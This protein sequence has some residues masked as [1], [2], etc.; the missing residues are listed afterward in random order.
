MY[1]SC[2]RTDLSGDDTGERARPMRVA[3]ATRRRNV[4]VGAAAAVTWRLK[5]AW[6]SEPPRRQSTSVG[7]RHPCVAYRA[8]PAPESRSN[9]STNPSHKS[10]PCCEIPAFVFRETFE[11]KTFPRAIVA[12]NEKKKKDRSTVQFVS[13]GSR[14][15]A[16]NWAHRQNFTRATRRVIDCPRGSSRHLRILLNRA[17]RE[18]IVEDSCTNTGISSEATVKVLD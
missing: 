3:D 16:S 13:L 17:G 2:V 11:A 7:A 8:S 10:S 12:H 9:R 15:S 14:W 5:S 18:S 6:N 1:R 4:D